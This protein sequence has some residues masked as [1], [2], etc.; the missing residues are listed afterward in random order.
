MTFETITEGKSSDRWWVATMGIMD[1][2]GG[3]S[4]GGSSAKRK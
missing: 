4:S 3:S 1:L 2:S